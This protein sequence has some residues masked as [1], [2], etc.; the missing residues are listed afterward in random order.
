MAGDGN[1]ARH[2]LG[3]AL[4]T[5]Q[6]FYAHSS[7]VDLG[8][9]ALDPALGRSVLAPPPAGAICPARDKSTVVTTG[10]FNLPKVWDAPPGRCLHGVDHLWAGINKDTSGS[11]FCLEA[12]A[13]A[14]PATVGFVLDTSSVTG[15]P[16]IRAGIAEALVLVPA[17]QDPPASCLLTGFGDTS[18]GEP[19]ET[20]DPTEF[21]TDVAGLA[22]ETGQDEQGFALTALSR[23]LGAARPGSRLFLL[24]DGPASDEAMA[25]HVAF[26]AAARQDAVDYLALGESLGR[27]RHDR[28]ADRRDRRARR[29]RRF[30]PRRSRLAEAGGGLAHEGIYAGTGLP[31]SDE[32]QPVLA[33]VDGPYGTVSYQIETAGGDVLSPVDLSSDGPRLDSSEFL[34]ELESPGKAYRVVAVG[35]DLSDNG[36]RRLY[37]PLFQP[38]P[39]TVTRT[40]EATSPCLPAGSST[41]EFEVRNDGP[42]APFDFIASD[43]NGV[44]SDIQPRSVKLARGAS[45]TVEVTVDVP[46][47]LASEGAP[48][49]LAVSATRRNRTEIHNGVIVPLR[50]CRF[51]MSRALDL[52]QGQAGRTRPRPPQGD[53]GALPARRRRVRPSGYSI[54]S[55]AF[56]TMTSASMWPL[57]FSRI[58]AY[59]G[60]RSRSSWSVSAFSSFSVKKKL[61][62]PTAL[63]TVS[64]MNWRAV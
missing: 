20:V 24:S 18:G 46:G 54:R 60:R 39:V 1:Q 49:S 64:V 59:S 61:F 5:M 12:I 44:V 28:G 50:A 55:F 25:G 45:R 40:D 52:E 32:A 22:P 27:Q 47:S 9:H 42:A 2:F 7:W 23:S 63:T 15:L 58:R 11:P 16:A 10:F 43:A 53:E 26:L 14:K 21:A 19:L 51:R 13:I 38:Q 33:A 30:A 62:S 17:S 34:G 29:F 3:V 41:L 4:H 37:A 31:G 6:D 35:T 8:N 48:V 36:F 56:W 57:P